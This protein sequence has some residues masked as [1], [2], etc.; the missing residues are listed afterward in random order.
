MGEAKKRIVYL[1]VLRIIACIA[2][3]VLHTSSVHLWH[4]DLYSNTWT[5]L[6]VFDGL[7]R[8]GVPVFVMISGA[9]LL[10]NKKGSL[11]ANNGAAAGWRREWQDIQKRIIRIATAFAFWSAIY[12]IWDFFHYHL[13]LFGIISTFIRGPV[14]LWFLFMIAGLYLI[15]PFL[16]MIANSKYVDYFII[17]GVIFN[18][19]LPFVVWLSGIINLQIQEII[20][21]PVNNINFS[22]ATGY[23]FYFVLGHW[24]KNKEFSTKTV[25]TISLFSVLGFIITISGTIFLSRKDG[26]LNEYFFNNSSIGIG[27]E[28]LGVYVLVKT[29]LEKRTFSNKAL[30][31][32]SRLSNSTFCIYL[33]HVLILNILDLFGINA[34][35]RNAIFMV[36]AV[37]LATFILSFCGY[38]FIKRIPKLNKYI[39]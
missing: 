16:K 4:A 20:G 1:D 39:I 27:L 14:H 12:T 28:A 37:A 35:S 9:L 8:F 13:N 31:V 17:L 36:P 6:I 23:P 26:A 34:I 10:E 3:V 2:V 25:V 11:S 32:I 21:Y 5:K 22:I 30:N 7:S 29:L 38:E 18:F 15:I 24:L 19:V 33:I